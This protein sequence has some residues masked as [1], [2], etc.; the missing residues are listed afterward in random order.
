MCLWYFFLGFSF[1]IFTFGIFG[2][3]FTVGDVKFSVC[4]LSAPIYERTAEVLTIQGSFQVYE[5]V[6]QPKPDAFMTS[7]RLH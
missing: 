7:S 4:I 2:K 5:L 6:L 1:A 3:L